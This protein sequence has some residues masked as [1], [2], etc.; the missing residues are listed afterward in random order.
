[1]PQLMKWWLMQGRRQDPWRV[2]RV[3]TIWR[4]PLDS[5]R[6]R[7]IGPFSTFE[8][9]RCRADAL[10]SEILA[11]KKPGNVDLDA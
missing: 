4:F 6:C 5:Y 11:E 3:F 7:V 9:A 10:N 2:W 8:E 1:M